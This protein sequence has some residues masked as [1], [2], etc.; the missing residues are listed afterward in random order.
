M[1]LFVLWLLYILCGGP[2]HPAHT[3]KFLPPESFMLVRAGFRFSL[4]VTVELTI[5]L[6]HSVVIGVIPLTLSIRIVF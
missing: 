1:C 2:L 5:W 4:M 6:C 3:D